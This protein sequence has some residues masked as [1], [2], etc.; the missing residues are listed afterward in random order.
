ML[1]H[2]SQ[3]HPSHTHKAMCNELLEIS[4]RPE[5]LHHIASIV[6]YC[7]LLR[8]IWHLGGK[9]GQRSS[10]QRIKDYRTDRFGYVFR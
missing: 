5:Q 6:S 4:T 7:T 1:L 9:S 8:R 10:L 2:S 3:S